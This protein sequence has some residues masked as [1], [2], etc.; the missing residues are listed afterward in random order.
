MNACVRVFVYFVCDFVQ[1]K[2]NEMEA[3][4]LEDLVDL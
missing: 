4:T 3:E 1:N 2:T